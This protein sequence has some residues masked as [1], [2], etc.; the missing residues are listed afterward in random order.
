MNPYQSFLLSVATGSPF[1]RMGETGEVDA[2]GRELVTVTKQQWNSV[3]EQNDKKMVFIGG[4]AVAG[5]AL[6]VLIRG[7]AK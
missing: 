5:L 6:G 7:F 2:Q 4:A 3:N 1:A